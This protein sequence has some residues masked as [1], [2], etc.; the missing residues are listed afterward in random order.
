VTNERSVL[1]ELFAQFALLALI[2]IGGIIAVVP[3]MQLAVIRHGW[4]DERTFV[5]LFALAQA[6]PGPNVVVVALVGW[7]VAGGLGALVAM[8][9]VCTPS[10]LLTFAIASGWSRLSSFGWVKLVERGLAPV[11]IGLVG[12]TGL[13]VGKTAA[14]G[15]ATWL[16][17][18]ATA[19]FVALTRTS[20]HLALA[21]G[22]AA[23]LLGLV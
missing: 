10:F 16:L 9:G 23:G 5:N 1:G 12:A 8:L 14:T 4:M 20:P 21:V 19:I 2:S 3:E 22:G 18:G 6:A 15:P 13:V 17:I 11:T 7:H